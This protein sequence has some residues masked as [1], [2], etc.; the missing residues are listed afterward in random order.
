MSCKRI[1]ITAFLLLAFSVP[2]S[3]SQEL[4]SARVSRAW[5]GNFFITAGEDRREYSPGDTGAGGL[6]LRTGGILQTGAESFAE[7]RLN[8]GLILIAAENTS[9]VLRENGDELFLDFIY[10]RLLLSGQGNFRVHSAAADVRLE[11][12]DIGIDYAFEAVGAPPRG[13]LPV[14]RVY[15]LNGSADLV[16]RRNQGIEAPVFPLAAGETLSLRIMGSQ[17][18]IERK[19]LGRD[20]IAYWNSRVPE[21]RL[22]PPEKEVPAAPALAEAPV[23]EVQ[24]RYEPPDYSDFIRVN[25]IKNLAIITGGVFYAL[26][27]TFNGLARYAP[28]MIGGNAESFTYASYG[29]IGLGTTVLAGSLF[30]NPKYPKANGPK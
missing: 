16:S 11:G 10:G 21:L 4:Q 20:I 13:D 6:I 9:L 18:Y 17:S 23:P 12:G 7:I 8:D 22:A 1:I 28:D 3:F 2:S 15:G 25:R 26:G 30:V 29:F 19:L 27:A 14:L 5:G 24:I